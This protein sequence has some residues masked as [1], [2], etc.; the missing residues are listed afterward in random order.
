VALA[1]AVNLLDVRDIVLGGVYARLAP[2]LIAAL[3]AELARRVVSRD[4]APARVRVSALGPY[5]AVRGAAGSVVARTLA[6]GV[7]G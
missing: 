5:A 4:V 2:W 6:A 3:D 7:S 1:A